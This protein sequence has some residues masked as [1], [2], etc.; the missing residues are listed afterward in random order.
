[1]IVDQFVTDYSNRFK[2]AHNTSRVLPE[3]GLP[4][5][6]SKLDNQELIKLPNLEEVKIALFSI[7]SKKTPGPD[8]FGVGFFKNYWH[9]IQNDLFN[10][11]T[12]VSYTHLTLPTKRIV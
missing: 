8:G 1:M 12:A 10:S 9:I 4:K 5:L 11:V 7:D 6:L 3:L 2:S